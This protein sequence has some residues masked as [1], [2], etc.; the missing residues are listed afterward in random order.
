MSNVVSIKAGNTTN[1]HRVQTNERLCLA[2][3]QVMNISPKAFDLVAFMGNG[4]EDSN[5]RV[6]ERWIHEQTDKLDFPYENDILKFLTE[7][8]YLEMNDAFTHIF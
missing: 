7:K 5:K 3:I 6:I 2:F 4:T 8:F 1:F